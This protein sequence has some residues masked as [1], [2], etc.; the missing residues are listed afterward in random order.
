MSN[1]IFTDISS[2]VKEDFYPVPSE[3]NIP[4]WY[5][6]TPGYIDNNKTLLDSTIKKC[7][8][9][10]DAMSCGYLL[11]T[12]ID[13]EVLSMQDYQVIT[14]SHGPIEFSDV[15]THPLRQAPHHPMKKNQ[16]YFK[17]NNPWSITTEAGYSCL[18]INPMHRESPITIMEGVVDTDQ[19]VYPVNMPFVLKDKFEGTIKAGTP[20]AQVIPF[21]REEFVMSFKNVKTEEFRLKKVS[22]ELDKAI[23]EG[24][25]NTYKNLWRS[26][27]SYR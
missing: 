4:E 13:M 24:V 6:K 9:V 3:K 23:D 16:S 25:L 20:F 21:K 2:S 17:I 22:D 1:I 18:F 12:P 11:K 19:Y 26:R 5:N 14:T 8:P 27:K 10:F 7:M 15:S